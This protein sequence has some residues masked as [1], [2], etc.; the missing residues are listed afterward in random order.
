MVDAGKV[1]ADVAL[2]NVGA[3]SGKLGETME[4]AV[5]AKAPAIGIGIENEGAFKNGP[6]DVAEGVVNYAV[7]VGCSGNG[8]GFGVADAK[9]TIG[10]GLI[11][12]GLEQMLDVAEFLFEV[13]VEGEDVGTIALAFLGF[14]GGEEEVVKAGNLGPEVAVTLHDFGFW[15]LDFGT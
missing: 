12:F 14:P 10:S 8:A 6:D 2:E 3:G 11:G 13:V 4:G 5:G 15:I 7:T 1:F 9:G